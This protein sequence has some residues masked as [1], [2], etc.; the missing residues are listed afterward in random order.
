MANKR[1][2]TRRVGKAKSYTFG[3]IRFRIK[4]VPDVVAEMDRLGWPTREG[5]ELDGVWL[6]G[7]SLI[8]VSSKLTTEQRAST[9]LHELLHAC[10]LD[11]ERQVLQLEMMLAPV[12]RK[13]GWNP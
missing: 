1:Q 6:P 5:E 10:G 8:L 11:D 3:S 7:C 4:D 12:L 13:Q 9:I 2:R